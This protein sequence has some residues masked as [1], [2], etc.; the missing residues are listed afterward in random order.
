MKNKININLKSYGIFL[1][2]IFS[3]TLLQAQNKTDSLFHILS[4]KDLNESEQSILYFEIAKAYLR[5]DLDSARIYA[6]KGLLLAERSEYIDGVLKNTITLGDIALR[7]DS[8]IEAS[9][10]YIKATKISKYASDKNSVLKVWLLL[11][12]THDLLSDYDRSLE[13]YFTGL[14]IADSLNLT[15]TQSTFYNNIAIIHNKIGNYR[16]AI[17]YYFKA[18]SILKET[19]NEYYYA[20]TLLNI[21]NVY[22]S[23]NSIDTAL[24]YLNKSK[25]INERINNHYGLLNYY[26][27]IGEIELRA[28]AYEKALI[29]FNHELKEINKLD[30]SFFG[31]RVFLKTAAYLDLGDVYL[32]KENYEKAIDNYNKVIRLATKSSF[33]EEIT[34]AY[35]GLSH[36]YEK[37][38]KSDSA[39]VYYKLFQ[40]YNDSLKREETIKKISELEMDYKLLEERK[41]MQLEK[42][43]MESRQKVKRL[44]Y[45][46]IIGASISGLLI[47][48]LLFIHQKDKHLQSQL[49]EQ[50]MAKELEYKN[51]E[52]TTNVMYLLKKNEFISEISNKLKVVDSDTIIVQPKIITD[53]INELDKNSSNKVWTE[54]E[55]RFQDIY[56]DFYKRLN[57]RFP[58]ITPNELKLCA[59]LKL[60]MSTKEIS[61]ITYQSTETLKKARFRLRKKLGLNRDENLM[62]FLNQV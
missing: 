24:I 16:K 31:S 19:D 25:K 41:L 28:G 5:T 26:A 17:D 51:K 8:L 11:G 32:R 40:K 44:I 3:A 4:T 43:R 1:L 12:Y 54:F 30:E 10:I 27:N 33:L 42:E 56:G 53:I 9:N 48:L 46:L 52:L 7:K 39:L 61:S 37:I 60:N 47:F 35:E 20:N 15:A 49:K 62:A 2:L 18:A 21:G 36:V 59:F 14:H 45:L 6:T 34:S 58:A 57:E 22:I 23:L 38:N 13:Y 50:N 29:S 55:T